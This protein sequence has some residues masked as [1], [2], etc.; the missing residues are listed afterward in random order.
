MRNL[1]SFLVFHPVLWGLIVLQSLVIAAWIAI[2]PRLSFSAANATDLL[3]LCATCVVIALIAY[4]C[5]A[6]RWPVAAERVGVM[7]MGILFLTLAFAGARFLNYLS[8]SSALPMADDLL[9]SWDKALGLDWH[10]YATRL[11]QYPDILPYLQDSYSR[12]TLL[13]TYVFLVLAAFGRT[14]RAKEFATLLYVGVVLTIGIAG[15]F[16]ADGAMARYVDD[17]LL[18]SFGPKTGVYFVEALKSVR[19]AKDFTLSF[20]HLPGLASFPSFHT[21]IALLIVYAWRDNIVTLLLAGTGGGLILLGTPVYGGHYF[22]DVIAGFFVTAVLA[23]AYT[24]VRSTS[25]RAPEIIMR[26][27]F[28]GLRRFW[29]P[30]PKA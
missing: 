12:A 14:E 2:D 10:A 28:L 5:R 13:I 17:H 8:M 29:I 9:D 30:H 6:T 27:P 4:A 18:A 23:F 26:E 22:V 25:S 7:V 3:T 16:P 24:A 1:R 21:I 20:A 11:S 19:E 15:F